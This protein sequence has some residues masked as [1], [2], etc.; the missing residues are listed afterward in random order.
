MAGEQYSRRDLGGLVR[1]AQHKPAVCLGILECIKHSIG[2]WS[3]KV[4]LLLCV[5]LVQLH[6]CVLCAVLGSTE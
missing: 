5:A 3:N 2:S 1:A 6:L 4:I